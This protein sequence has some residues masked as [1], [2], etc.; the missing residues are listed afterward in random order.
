L[1]NYFPEREASLSVREAADRLGLSTATVYA[2][3][4]AG[5]LAH[6]RVGMAIRILRADLD[7]FVEIG[8]TKPQPRRPR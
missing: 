8:G 2:A 1:S 3:C 6:H 7:K 5:Q 4:G